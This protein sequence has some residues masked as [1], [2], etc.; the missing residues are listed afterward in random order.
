[1]D[2]ASTMPSTLW[3]PVAGIRLQSVSVADRKNIWGVTLDL[4]LCKLNPETQQWILVAVTSET[5]NRSRFSASSAHSALTN[6][7]ISSLAS[8]TP[9]TASSFFATKKISSL[10]P[11]L[12]LSSGS[13]SQESSH[14]QQQQQPPQQKQTQ[15][16]KDNG[17][18]LPMQR[19][20]SL[21]LSES[22]T[23][24]DTTVQVSAASDGTVVRLDTTQK[25]WYLIAPHDHADFE[26]DVIWIDLGHFW[27][28][29]SVASISQ[30]WGL[31]ETGDIYYGTSDR[32]VQLESSVTS[33]A[34][35]DKPT[36]THIAVGHDNVVLATDAHSGIVFRLKTHPTASH[37]PVWTAMPGTGTAG[38]A[39]TGLHFKSCSLSSANFIVGVTL[40]GH[41]YRFTHGAWVSLGGGA[42]MNNVGIGSDGYVLGV[43]RDGDLFGCQLQD[44]VTIPRR[45]SSR[46]IQLNQYKRKE[47]SA[48]SSP[49]APNA[50]NIPTTPRL[51]AV[52][53]RP[54]ASPREL[55]EMAT[56]T[57]H[58]GQM[59]D[60]EP[61][62]EFGGP[63]SSSPS[64][65]GDSYTRYALS[66]TESQLSKRSYASDLPSATA[67]T[68]LNILQQQRAG[69]PSP[70]P[71]GAPSASNKPLPLRIQ[72]KG[73][74][75]SGRYLISADES[76]G[77]SYFSS[78]PHTASSMDGHSSPPT[79]ATYDE[80]LYSA[81]SRA[82][83]A[84][85]V[86]RTSSPHSPRSPY[87][88]LAWQN[89]AR[90]S[91]PDSPSTPRMSS[92]EFPQ[93]YAAAS[94]IGGGQFEHKQ[95]FSGTSSSG[96]SP[97]TYSPAKQRILERALSRSRS[98]QSQRSHSSTPDG[99]TGRGSLQLEKENDDIDTTSDAALDGSMS[100]QSQPHDVE[101]SIARSTASAT[102][103]EHDQDMDTM[104][105]I[106]D[107]DIQNQRNS[108]DSPSIITP[109]T[110]QPKEQGSLLSSVSS[111]PPARMSEMIQQEKGSDVNMGVNIAEARP[112]D[113]EEILNETTHKPA[114]GWEPYKSEWIQG[115]S[116]D[117]HD[118][119]APTSRTNNGRSLSASQ[120]FWQSQEEHPSPP[121]PSSSLSSQDQTRYQPHSP[122]LS[123]GTLS[124]QHQTQEFG[125]DSD[126]DAQQD[127]GPDHDL[128]LDLEYYLST[129]G[130][131]STHRPSDSSDIL[132]QEQQEYLRLTRLRSSRQSYALAAFKNDKNHSKYFNTLQAFGGGNNGFGIDEKSELEFDSSTV[133]ELQQHQQQQQYGYKGEKQEVE[134]QHYSS[135]PT[136]QDPVPEATSS[137]FQRY[138]SS[139]MGLFKKKRTQVP[140]IVVKASDN[141]EE[142]NSRPSYSSSHLQQYVDTLAAQATPVDSRKD[143]PM[144]TITNGSLGDGAAA[145]APA[146]GGGGGGAGTGGIGETATATPGANTTAAPN[147]GIASGRT[148][149]SGHPR[150]PD[151][152]VVHRN[153]EQLRTGIQGEDEQGRW[154]GGTSA[155]DTT[156][157][158]YD[159]EIH[160]KSKCCNIL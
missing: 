137:A 111:E 69:S 49:Q 149:L 60:E 40:D 102:I 125:P 8:S 35:Y 15:P 6:T 34:G 151:T 101:P 159:P 141:D 51:Q 65:R 91:R 42:K 135:D 109:S 110:R 3:H 11:S 57:T 93:G 97:V 129:P 24:A 54:M 74:G 46:N 25:A 21:P 131:G 48:P 30:I 150:G 14:Q 1:M 13:L 100:S 37:P 124:D 156:L 56:T 59:D 55:F 5:V 146:A 61:V 89:S 16:D 64:F 126:S 86:L 106:V 118:Q 63:R 148:S 96:D 4:Q 113:K 83:R 22:E 122:D 44:T 31:S 80:G 66:R 84:S 107:S 99:D 10:L 147:A 32:F 20:G 82:S 92:Q 155:N 70:G 157:R 153:Y 62:A 158:H 145:V 123:H 47:S 114:A 105:G 52:S 39:G 87:L 130:L 67:P 17:L 19:Q 68:G 94:R 152:G 154:I 115:G 138:P 117:S 121:L 26:K 2:P 81:K 76:A 142:A 143:V 75:L 73:V 77:D 9:S 103:M 79:H 33:G 127:Q 104:R 88:D 160:H 12:R 144:I 72:T 85:P 23:D 90:A 36:F 139:S 71:Y 108:I 50:P 27:K 38:A 98:F 133:G 132:M 53:K 41:V 134:Q 29:V 78:R 140:P 18:S 136:P 7:S 116:G 128:D 45:V 43:D 95:R 120:Q 58:R 112:P 119:V 28:V